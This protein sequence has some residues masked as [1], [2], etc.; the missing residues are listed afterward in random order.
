MSAC[1]YKTETFGFGKPG[2]QSSPGFLR[3]DGWPGS[4]PDGQNGMLTPILCEHKRFVARTSACG[5]PLQH[6]LALAIARS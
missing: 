3:L 6:P 4:E 5:L 2:V 1:M